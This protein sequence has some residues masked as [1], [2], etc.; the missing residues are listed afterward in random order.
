MVKTFYTD[1]REYNMTGL[2]NRLDVCHGAVYDLI[3][4][5]YGLGLNF[6]IGLYDIL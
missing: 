4:T 3:R 5:V 6:E 2:K 1:L